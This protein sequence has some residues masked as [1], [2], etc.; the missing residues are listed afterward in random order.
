MCLPAHMLT[1][2]AEIGYKVADHAR[3]SSIEELG[4]IVF[5]FPQGITVYVVIEEGQIAQI[6]YPKMWRK[7]L[8]SFDELN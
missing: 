8:E 7:F 2:S 5:Y 1:A 4:L 3:I 6:C